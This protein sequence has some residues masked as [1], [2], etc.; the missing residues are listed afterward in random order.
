MRTLE[1]FTPTISCLDYCNRV[2]TL[3]STFLF[4]SQPLTANIGSRLIFVKD[5]LCKRD[6]SATKPSMA[7]HLKIKAQ[8]LIIPTSSSP[9]SS[10][11]SPPT[12]LLAHSDSALPQT[13]LATSFLGSFASTLSS[14]QNTCSFLLQTIAP[15]SPFQWSP[16]WPLIWN[17]NLFNSGFFFS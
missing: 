1:C 7:S 17:Y 13:C 16:L 11:T 5:T 4:S 3:L 12:T 14:A 10:W 2:L 6:S 8:N 15:M 9:H